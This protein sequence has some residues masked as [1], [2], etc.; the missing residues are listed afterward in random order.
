MP[1]CSFI[2][3]LVTRYIDG[4]LSA[5]ERDLVAAHVRVCA[6]CH[7]RVAAE[8]AV[9]TLIH[10]RKST[11]CA[12][13]APESLRAKCSDAARLDSLRA[14][15]GAADIARPAPAVAPVGT[16]TLT[17]PSVDPR[18]SGATAVPWR[19]RLAPLALA[20]S[21]VLVVG[22]AFVYQVTDASA[23]V[24]AAELTADHVKCFAMNR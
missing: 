2:D 7:S 16:V 21:L 18:F 13:R 17:R 9:R 11:L 10:A 19:A 23:R 3:P 24:M 12:I 15:A 20:A 8:Q 5:A 6:P 22:G 4:E 1:N 14:A